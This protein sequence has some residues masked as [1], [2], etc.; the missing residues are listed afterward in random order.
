MPPMLPLKGFTFLLVFQCL[1]E[2]ISRLLHWPIP[3]PV[4]GMLL[5]VPCL[6]F[7]S[8]REPVESCANFL[9]SHLSLLFLPISVGVLTQL[10][11]LQEY[12]IRILLVLL[13]SCALGLL[14]TGCLLAWWLPSEE[15]SKE[16][17]AAVQEQKTQEEA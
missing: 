2:L 1:G 10:P 16:A 14:A 3:G 5:L 11:L 12:S 13:I 17:L 4:L 9:I 15:R 7:L 8:V 6:S